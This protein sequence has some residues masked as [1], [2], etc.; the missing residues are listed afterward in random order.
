ME[1][2]KCSICSSNYSK[3]KK[4]RLCRKRMRKHKQDINNP[5]IKCCICMKEINMSK[6]KKSIKLNDKCNHYYHSCCFEITKKYIHTENICFI[7]NKPKNLTEKL[8]IKSVN[9][10]LHL[11]LEITEKGTFQVDLTENNKNIFNQVVSLWKFLALNQEH[12]CAYSQF[13][14]SQYYI[15]GVYIEKDEETS[16]DYLLASACSN[17]DKAQYT[18]ACRYY[19]GI[20]V[21]KNLSKSLYWFEKAARNNNFDAQFDYSQIIDDEKKSLYWLEKASSNN[22]D[23]AK[24]TLGH[25]YYERSKDKMIDGSLSEDARKGVKLIIEAS[26]LGNTNAMFWL[27]YAHLTGETCLSKSYHKSLKYLERASFLNHSMAMFNLGVVYS[28]GLG[29]EKDEVKAFN[30]ILKS[31]LFENSTAQFNL[32]KIYLNGDLGQT[33]NMN[34]ALRWLTAAKDNKCEEAIDA[35]NQI[36]VV[37]KYG[38]L[39]AK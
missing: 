16:L 36:Y 27:G 14:L 1:D 35:Y 30:L 22:H 37:K 25:L 28:K 17:F 23:S 20:G 2:T 12:N 34:A 31:A 4:C 29:V 13:N 7:C 6:E 32:F 8:Y 11:E 18:L 19:Q 3:K 26:I 9:K 10:C 33:K 21:E 39:N 38:N 24:F 5:I 15:Q